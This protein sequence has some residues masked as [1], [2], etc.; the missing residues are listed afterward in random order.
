MTGA[1]L[2]GGGVR[3]VRPKESKVPFFYRE[4]SIKQCRNSAL[5]YPNTPLGKLKCLSVPFFNLKVEVEV[6]LSAF[7]LLKSSI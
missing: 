2:G 1:D 3:G 6:P 4:F 5:N 7:K